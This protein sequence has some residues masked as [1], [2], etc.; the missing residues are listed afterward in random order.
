MM[1]SSD[2]FKIVFGDSVRTGQKKRLHRAIVRT[3]EGIDFGQVRDVVDI[4]VGGTNISKRTEEDSVFYLVRDLLHAVEKLA[5]GESL[6]GVSFYEGPWELV[7]QRIGTRVYLTFYRGGT[8]P[9]IVVKDRQVSFENLARGVV[10]SAVELEQLAQDLTPQATDDPLIVDLVDARKRIERLLQARR[11]PQP[12]PGDEPTSLLSTRWQHPRTTKGFS[13]GFKFAA[14]QTD[15]LLPTRLSGYDLYALLFTGTLVLHARDRRLVLSEGYLVLQIECLLSSVRQLLEAWEEGRPIGVRWVA[16][17][18]VVG[19]QLDRQDGLTVSLAD[20]TREDA[21]AQLNDL[22]PWEYADAVLGVARELRRLIVQVNPAHRRNLRLESIGRE[23][24]AL[25][26]WSKAQRQGAVINPHTERYRQPTEPTSTAHASNVCRRTSRLRFD[27]RWRVEVE[28]LNLSNAMLL[29]DLVLLSN[30]EALIGLGAEDGE[31]IWRRELDSLDARMAPVGRD[32]LVRAAPSGQ[33]DLIDLACGVLRWRATLEPRSGGAPVLLVAEQGPAPGV[34]ITAE[35]ERRLVAIDPRTGE[36]RWR[37]TTSRGGRF[38]LRRRGRLL[39]VT[40]CDSHFNAVD[41]EDGSLVW[42]YA[43]RTKFM[44]PPAICGDTVLLAGGRPGRP[45]GRVFAF[46]AYSGEVKWETPLHGGAL[47]VP[48]IAHRSML[49]PVRNGNRHELVALDVDTGEPLFRKNCAGWAESCALMAL[50]NSFV[51]NSAGG[52]VRSFDAQDGKEK[53][54]A[55]LGPT[56]SEDV[57][58][59]L[60]PVLRGGALFVPADTVYVVHPEDGSLI[61]SLG[62]D[63]PVPDLLQVD[64]SCAVLV[65]EQSGHIAM[66]SLLSRLSVV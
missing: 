61:H 30:G 8:K 3:D 33:I 36:L 22:T 44:T 6:T 19:I 34:I 58:T 60:K 20:S 42:R 39:Y 48:L 40:S 41:I 4:V 63:A 26:E 10:A 52:M 49:V 32:A 31:V 12:D 47:T 35:Q 55:V 54:C 24:K 16:E 14:S 53:W 21:I 62:Q 18:L 59:N 2:V 1:R 64:P 38:A 50:E 25:T 17:R 66:F 28:G 5:G 29:K 43:E 57:P 15:L 46:D 51:V 9:L 45:E 65:A 7:M 13:F 37:F 11:L 23:V 27:E 56:V